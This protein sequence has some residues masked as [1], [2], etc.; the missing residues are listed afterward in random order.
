MILHFCNRYARGKVR[1]YK[2]TETPA[3]YAIEGTALYPPC[4]TLEMVVVH[5]SEHKDGIVSLLTRPA[6]F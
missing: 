2:L 3:G 6:R 5:L 4:R 1:H